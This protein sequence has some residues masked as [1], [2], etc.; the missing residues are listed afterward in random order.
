L[1]LLS[2]LIFI[3]VLSSVAF[4]AVAEA[5]LERGVKGEMEDVI[6]VNADDWHASIAA[7]PLAIWSEDNRTIVKP[8]LIL[9]K[10]VYAGDR[11]G[12]VE[13][14]DLT[15][16]GAKAVLD[17]F[18]SANLSAITIH[19]A[20][21]P[22]KGLVEAAHKDGLKAYVTASLELP[23]FSFPQSG[24]ID[25]LPE[26]K[27]EM[28]AKAGLASP[29]PD[30]SK[31][32][33]SWMQVPNPDT[34]GNASYFCPV[35]PEVR[36]NLYNQI[37][38][39]IDDYKVDGIVLYK[40]GF[41]DEN[42]CFCDVCKEKFYQDTG[43]DITK[44]NANSYN[45]ER[46]NQWKQD[47]I[48]DVVDDCRNIT[49][50]LGPVKLGVALDNPFDRSQGYNY[51]E[52]SKVADFSL[53]SPLSV[54]D[55]QLACSMSKKPVY[56]RLSD[57]YVG[58]VLSTQNVEGAVRY[59]E[60]LAKAG[61]RG[62]SFEYNVVYT[63]LWSELEP[64]SQAARWL[65]QKLGGKTLRIG[66][67]S[68]ISDSKI[69]ANNSFELAEKLSR[70]WKSSPGA[71]IVSEN[72]TSAL[73]AAPIA[74]YLNWPLLFVDN[75][76]PKETTIA[77]Q[78]LNAK[79][80]VIVGPVSEAV[81]QNLSQMNLTIHDGSSEFLVK[82]M[83]ERGES[84]SMVVMTNSH[85]LSLLPPAPNPLVERTLVKDL[86][87]KIEV[88][89]SQIPAEEVGEIV[90]LNITLTNSGKE[91]QKD[92]RLLDVFPMGRFIKWPRPSIG[93]V[94]VTDPYTGLPSNA[95]SA[96]LNGSML[97]WN[98]DRLDSGKS[99][100]LN[101]E[102]ELLY[103]T[104]SGWKER[105][106]TGST[107]AYEGYSYN[108]TI[109]NKDDWPV[110]NLTYPTWIYSGRTNISWNLD[111]D[112]SYTALNLFS[113]D[114]R[115]GRL[116]ITG[117]EPDRLYD[118]RVQLL[119]PGVWKFNVEAGNG[120]THKT[121]NYTIRV[122]SNV[123]AINITA[124]SHTKVPRLSL[125][126]AQA[127]S[128]RKALLV[129][130]A[131]DP[132]QIDPLN[133]EDALRQKVDDLK[134]SPKN[135]MI[136][137]DPGSLPF[138]PT[139]LI[140]KLS[141]VM[142]YEVHRDY[143]LSIN[144]DNYSNIAVGR[145]MGLSVYDASQLMARTFAYDRLNGSWKENG[146]VISSP[147]LSYP[148]APTALSI[149]DYLR[150]AG[151]NIK[152]L[153]FEE[154]T[155]QQAVSQMNNGQNI[156]HFDHHGN[157]ESWLL[158]EWSLTDTT[159]TGKH[160]KELILPPQTTTASACVTVNL[161]GYYLNIS[162]TKMY[163]PKKL[164]DSIALSFIRAGAVNYIGESALSWIFV[165]DDYFKRFYQA[166]VYENATV[167]QAQLDADNLFRLKSRGTENIKDISQYDEDLPNWDTSVHEMLNQTVYM[168]VIL[169]DP[170]FRPDLPFSPSLPYTTE[171]KAENATSGNK[172]VLKV[173]VTLNNESATDWIYWIETDSSNGE[174]NLNAPPAI[175]GEVLLP[176]DA[177]KIIVRQN[178]LVVWHDEATFGE[179]KKVMW[180][181]I[182]PRLSE[183]RR[184]QMEY[185]LIPGQIQIINVTAGW[186]A[187]AVYLKPKDV[188]ANKYLKN[189]PYRGIFSIVGE[190]WNFGMKDSG[191][192]NVTRFEA[193]KGYLIDSADNFTIVIA[194]KPVDLPYRLDLH[195]GWN[196][197]GLPV[198]NTM[199]LNNITVNAEHK[200]YTY[201][202]AVKKGLVS[203]F[204]WKYDNQGWTHLGENENLETGR[205]YLVESMGEAK[206]EFR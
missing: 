142:E 51:A 119:T 85:D 122:R 136:V 113:P 185:E 7:T 22:V 195:Q 180:P 72:Y 30:D 169:G 50:D 58:Y 1:R 146:L 148:Q 60:D 2:V 134:L 75:V 25:A 99:A 11:N 53:I 12:W 35:N 90:R 76:L 151:L 150:E 192:L 87:V 77:L 175:I 114:G 15:K 31:I 145:I 34:G 65:L 67:V 160:V 105:L 130:V 64:P 181:I 46:W 44:V 123:D 167:G 161:K 121:E 164:D 165:S 133:E 193:G 198:N 173:S 80:V 48:I 4:S 194:G 118:M 117:I 29:I 6:L 52:I 96:F 107:V 63:P 102:V 189:K 104:D 40:I 191:M 124:F 23:T 128:A 129:D 132:Q 172:T 177:D 188:S 21:D 73:N 153:R 81:R 205:A 70:H 186:N 174:L 115:S 19:G 137:G 171:A 3:V 190:G 47:Q 66:N 163:I 156:V 183:V 41:Q 149:G 100:S 201:P 125:V 127:A 86:V 109:E 54:Q 13:E 68:W 131:K 106:D 32:N 93:K 202:E 143:Q 92:V 203:A 79:E 152:N 154:A 74:S 116:K 144:D 138:I 157:E 62:L 111:R 197:I 17:T 55:V 200:R 204:V 170:S 59:I 97:R 18:K 139:G 95:T 89:P 184:F 112:A 176:K 120:Y 91:V 56:V 158:S 42:Y 69:E 178:G 38:T 179:Q 36:D 33:P 168:D 98:L 61:A 16:Y 83:L 155:Y 199:D 78:S 141:S 88:S 126:A 14:S 37:E 101:I 135:L 28:L 108:H 206:L 49:N 71:V 39:L 187:V 196:M 162:G 43:I 9:P 8:L 45:L 166:L 159:L 10:D 84:P 182:R 103:P 27:I 57:D 20:G 110:I 26:A 140:Q 94:N 147:P 82:T 5:T 24:D